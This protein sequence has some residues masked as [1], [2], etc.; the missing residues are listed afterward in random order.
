MASF[1]I[2]GTDEESRENEVKIINRCQRPGLM[3]YQ[4]RRLQFRPISRPFLHPTLGNNMAVN[5]PFSGVPTVIHAGVNSG[6]AE[7][8]TTDGATT[9]FALIQSGQNFATTVAVGHSVKNTSVEGYA[10]V[11]VVNSDTLLTLDTDIM[12]TGQNFEINQIWVGSIVAGTWNFADSGKITITA[13]NDN[14]EASFDTNAGQTW[15]TDNFA[16]FTGKVDLDAYD[17]ALNS[18]QIQFGLDGT[19]VGDQ[20]TLDDFIDTADFAEQNFAIPLARFNFVS[21][22]VNDF[23]IRI[24]RS[25]GVKPTI[26]FDDLQW[27]ESGFPIEYAIGVEPGERFHIDQLVFSMADNV[28]GIATVAGATEN[29]SM[30][31]LSFDKFLGVSALSNGITFTRRENGLVV[32][33]LLFKQL[34]DML[35]GGG[36]LSNVISDATNTYITIAVDF[37]EPIIMDGNFDDT[38]TLTINDNLSGLLLFSTLARGALEVE[39][40]I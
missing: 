17:P 30:Q 18:I 12:E 5:V 34:S 16:S 23:T 27:E 14:D 9:A 29:H 25:G 35:G 10:L 11:T 7:S 8:G 1:G 4:E 32:L 38:L 28:T 36:T 19:P 22:A 40:R 26:K 20:I 39:A 31:N 6:T 3:V 13:A 24:T 33:T 37:P 2:S 21:T 15:D